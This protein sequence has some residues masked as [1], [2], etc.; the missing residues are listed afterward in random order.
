VGLF[1]LISAFNE[2][3]KKVRV[4]EFGEI[5]DDRFTVVDKIEH[6]LGRLQDDGKVVFSTLFANAAS[7]NE[8]VCTFLAVLEL[9][10]LRQVVAQQ[11]SDFGEIVIAKGS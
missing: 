3:L 5:V 4:E 10:R 1:D 11:D 7:R 8:I 9:I 6:V 2:A